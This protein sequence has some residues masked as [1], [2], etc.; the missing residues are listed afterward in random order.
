MYLN[1]AGFHGFLRDRSTPNQ[2]LQ[3]K[4]NL[5]K[6]PGKSHRNSTPGYSLRKYRNLVSR[7][8]ES[9]TTGH[10]YQNL[11]TTRESSPGDS[12]ATIRVR[13]YFW[14]SLPKEGSGSRIDYAD[15][16]HRLHATASWWDCEANRAGKSCC[17]CFWSSSMAHDKKA[18]LSQKHL[19]LASTGGISGAESNRTSVAGT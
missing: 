9:W 2:I 19:A 4:K 14:S 10:R 13:L 5:K 15:Y 7:W 18:A 17:C 1:D 12:T 11:G 6:I 3:S 8:S 16:W